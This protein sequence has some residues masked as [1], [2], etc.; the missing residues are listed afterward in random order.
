MEMESVILDG[1]RNQ[2]KQKIHLKDGK[3]LLMYLHNMFLVT[4]RVDVMFCNSFLQE[5]LQLLINAIFL[6]EDG[7][8]DCAFYSVRQAGEVLNTML[9]LANCD[10]EELSK[11]NNK[12]RFPMD[13]KVRE[14]LQKL[15]YGYKEISDL[16][17]FYFDYYRKLIKSTHKII[18]K[19]GVDTF[20]SD[21]F[22]EKNRVEREKL[23]IE[24]LKYTIGIEIIIFMILDPI[25][26]VMADEELAMKFYYNPMT[27]AID[28]DYFKKYLG[29]TDVIDKIKSSHFYKDF[30]EQFES[31]EEMNIATYSVIKDN[32]WD[33]AALDDIENQIHLLNTY[34]KYMFRILKA[35]IRVTKFY[36]MQGWDWYF[37]TYKSRFL[38]SGYSSAELKPY[39]DK[40]GE[41]NQAFGQKYI[42]TI[43]MYDD[44]LMLEH[45][46]K[47]SEQEIIT[48][49]QIEKEINNEYEKVQPILQ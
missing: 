23:F 12:E 1:L 41:F 35:G 29:L 43:K 7:F 6:Y 32:A 26:L 46:D 19:Q 15:D 21:S 40:K 16:L 38:Y 13:G 33:I 44:N 17:K 42:S 34:E 11:W 47:L 37:T 22:N 2:Y 14:Q 20:Y 5:S 30:A 39:K 36:Y 8:F 27:E 28:A 9:Y 18:H 25:S 45:D 4:G 10:N 3:E 31:N 48:I 49:K 24:S